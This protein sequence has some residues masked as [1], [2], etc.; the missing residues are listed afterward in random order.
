MAK[1]SFEE[2]VL[3][4]RQLQKEYNRSRDKKMLSLKIMA[5]VGVD[6]ALC[7]LFPE[8]T[9]PEPEEKLPS[10]FD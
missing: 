6:E 9:E 2:M 4:M 8:Q 1:K 7:A 3:V 5:E 10:L